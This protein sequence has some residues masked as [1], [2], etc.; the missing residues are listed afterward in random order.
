MIGPVHR[1][2]I[3][4]PVTI[5]WVYIPPLLGHAERVGAVSQH[6]GGKKYGIMFLWWVLILF[7]LWNISQYFFYIGI[8]WVCPNL[9][10]RQLGLQELLL[11]YPWGRG[12]LGFNM[13]QYMTRFFYCSNPCSDRYTLGYFVDAFK[14]VREN[15]GLYQ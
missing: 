6:K 7:T 12:S 1:K 11:L 3:T 5:K 2:M 15:H 9:V 14:L 4:S 8:F 10:N 13:P